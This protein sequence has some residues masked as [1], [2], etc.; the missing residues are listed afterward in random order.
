MRY[1]RHGRC[2]AIVFFSFHGFHETV[3]FFNENQ[4]QRRFDLAHSLL[5]LQ[6]RAIENHFQIHYLYM[7]VGFS[8]HLVVH[9]KFSLL[10]RAATLKLSSP[11]GTQTKEP[12]REKACDFKFEY[13]DQTSFIS[14]VPCD[15]SVFL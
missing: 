15:L 14:P 12:G 5:A 8:F 1:N 10:N 4:S 13:P 3:T 6:T 9:I 11:K 7:L 2:A